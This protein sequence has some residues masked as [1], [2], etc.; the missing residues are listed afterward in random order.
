MCG[1]YLGPADMT[2]NKAVYRWAV[3]FCFELN[4]PANAEGV[5]SYEKILNN[6]CYSGEVLIDEL[7]APLVDEAIFAN[8]RS[9]WLSLS[10][11]DRQ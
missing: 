7:E 9:Y 10:V 8:L 5:N 11:R 6:P 1:F 3:L 4:V 2:A